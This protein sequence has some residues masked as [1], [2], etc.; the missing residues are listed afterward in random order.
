MSRQPRARPA[1]TFDLHGLNGLS[2]FYVADLKTEQVVNICV[3]QSSRA[4]DSERPDIAAER[5]DGAHYGIG[6]VICDRHCFGTEPGEKC[7]GTV[8]TH[9]RVVCSRGRRC[10]KVFYELAGR[11]VNHVPVRT[12]KR[13]HPECLP[14]GSERHAVTAVSVV[15][16]FPYFLFGS[17]IPGGQA[18]DGADIDHVEGSTYC[19]SFN[20]FGR[21]ARGILPGRNALNETEIF[22][23]LENQDSNTAIADVVHSARNRDVEQIARRDVASALGTE[24]RGNGR[25]Q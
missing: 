7:L 10:L 22:I 8:R 20:V 18:S 4:I 12:A 21:D 19:D 6:G 13:W 17:Q 24:T 3:D 11:C 9:D 2:R 23:D 14:I 15:R 25:E 1:I 5:S 16:L